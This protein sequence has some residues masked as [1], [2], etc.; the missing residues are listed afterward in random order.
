M[1]ILLI[2]GVYGL[3]V[4][5]LWNG[6]S[7]SWDMPSRKP[8]SFKWSAIKFWKDQDRKS[9]FLTGKMLGQFQCIDIIVIG[10][11]IFEWIRRGR[12]EGK[13]WLQS[14]HR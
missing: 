2:T 14:R 10:N 6:K 8:E 12:E 7:N 5:S 3:L 11:W 1:K 9:E 13:P 4:T